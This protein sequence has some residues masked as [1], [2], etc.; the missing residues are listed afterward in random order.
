MKSGSAGLDQE[1]VEVPVLVPEGRA[2][3]EESLDEAAALLAVA[4][5]AALEL[6]L[7]N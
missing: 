2:H 3:G 6:R 4:P 1:A 5:E 7:L